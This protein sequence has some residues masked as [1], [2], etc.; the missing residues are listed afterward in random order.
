MGTF[1][2]FEE[3]ETWKKA[4][5]LSNRI[6]ELTNRGTFA[7]DFA[8]RDQINRAAGSVMD[9]IAEGCGRGGNREFVHFLAISRGSTSETLSQLYRALDRNHIS[10]DEFRS[11]S[12][13]TIE[14]TRMLGSLMSY[15]S[16]SNFKGATFKER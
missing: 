8:L 2:S 12:S 9:N 11:L 3:I 4:R 13:E 1:N 5:H 15:L 14:I 10:E 16:R 7:S 6:Y